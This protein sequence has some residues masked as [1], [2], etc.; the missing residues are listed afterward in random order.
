[1]Q[2]SSNKIIITFIV[3]GGLFLGLYLLGQQQVK[4]SVDSLEMEFSDF[5]VD[6]LSIIPPEIDLTLTYKIKNP[7]D[8]SLKVSIDGE[9]YY[10]S[11][12]ITPL[13]VV[14]RIIPA[15]GSGEIDVQISL[16]GT[17]LEAIGD[18]QN[19][20]KYRLEGILIVRSQYLGLIPVSVT[21]DLTELEK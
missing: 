6:K 11:T 20:K 17:L 2:N 21:F 14:E 13:K 15:K 18:P 4:E 3:F 12:K 16:N 10:G 19:E 8:M 7:G 9:I 5:K 1:M